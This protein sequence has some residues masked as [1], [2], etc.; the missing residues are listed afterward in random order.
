MSS[1]IMNN[2][3]ELYYINIRN[4]LFFREGTVRVDADGNLLS[5]AVISEGFYC[6]LLNT[7]MGWNLINA[8]SEE[9]NA[10]G[11]DLI[12][13]G[14]KIA[15]Q[16]SLT[17]DH[18]KVQRSIDK[19]KTDSYDGWHF[20]F[21]PI[22]RD[23]PHFREDFSLPAG[24]IFDKSKDVLS[25]DCILRKV[26]ISQENG[27]IDKLKNLS[28]LMD[29]YTK[30]LASHEA[31]CKR[32]YDCLCKARD[33]HP[34]FRLMGEDGIDKQLFPH[35]DELIPALG[36]VDG[37]IAPIWE[38]IKAEQKENF[39]HVI[40][41]G[42]G[43]IG[44][45]VSLLSVTEDNDLLTR[46]PAIYIHMYD[47]VYGGKCLT[48]PEF[49][50]HYADHEEIDQL[51]CE[52]G[53][54]KLMLLLDGLNEVAYEHQDVILRSIKQWASG[55][56]GAQLIIS[57]RPIPGRRL[58]NLLDRDVLHI[59]LKGLEK[60]QI[61][62]RLTAWK[63]THPVDGAAIW[64]TLKL[65][66][67]LTL[68]AK[69]AKLPKQT[70]EGYPLSVREVTGQASLIWNYLQREL[71]REQMGEWP[72][73]CAI[74]CE[75][76]APYIAYRMA[77]KNAFELSHDEAEDLVEDAVGQIDLTVLPTHLK[78]VNA[79]RRHGRKKLP[80]T[81]WVSFVLEQSGIF[82][83]AK[84]GEKD[85]DR[86]KNGGEKVTED[87][88]AFMHQNFRDCLAGLWLVNQAEMAKKGE[89]PG[90]WERNQ[91]H[92]ALNYAAELMEPEDFKRLWK[93]NSVAKK[94]TTEESRKNHTSTCNLLELWKRNKKLTSE[95]DFS[96]MDL[97][98]LSLTHYLG[99]NGE[100]LPL[101][102]KSTLSSG[103]RIDRSVF[104][105]E[106]H[107][108]AIACLAVLPDGRVVSG[109]RDNTL[110]VWDAA[111]GQCLKTLRGH[112]EPITCVAA[113]SNEVII[114]GSED[115]TIGVWNLATGQLLKRLK[116]HTSVVNCVSPLPDGRVI[117]ASDDCTLRV[118]DIDTEESTLLE[119][120]TS[121]ICCIAVLSETNIVS[122]S[123]DGTLR[124]WNTNTGK[125]IPPMN[126][127]GKAITCV[128]IHPNGLIISGSLDNMVRVWDPITRQC[129][130][131]LT[132]LGDGVECLAVLP[133]GMVASATGSIPGAK[134]S[135]IQLW[136][137]SSGEC[138]KTLKGHSKPITSLLVLPDGQVISG[139]D[140]KTIRVWDSA[141]GK[142]LH[143]LKTH[144]DSVSC[145]AALSD[146][147]IISGSFDRSIIIWDPESGKPSQSL[148]NTSL[149]V[150]VIQVLPND[151][152]ITGSSDGVLRLWNYKKGRCLGFLGQHARSVE[153]LSLMPNGML[154]SG[155][156]DSTIQIWDIQSR[157]SKRGIV[158][159]NRQITGLTVLSEA[160]IAFTTGDGFLYRW[161]L[162]AGSCQ[163]EHNAGKR[164]VCV[165][166]LADGK[167]VC[168]SLSK[169][170][171]MIDLH[172][173]TPA[174]DSK[175]T[176]S[177]VFC[178]SALST[179]WVIG[180]SKDGK[181][182][183][184]NLK[185]GEHRPI[186]P[187]Q[188]HQKAVNDITGIEEGR[189]VS[190]SDD[191]TIRVWDLTI[192]KPLESTFICDSPVHCI[193]VL[194]DGKVLSGSL[195]GKIRK[196]DLHSKSCTDLFAFTEVDVYGMDFSKA[197][198]DDEMKKLL[199]Q[200][201]AQTE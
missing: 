78:N 111:T 131:R 104:E 166:S 156:Y 15:L 24:L 72:V 89:L 77:M 63:I 195:D 157:K 27:D 13:R 171:T 177:A 88:Y 3:D 92:I 137:I 98:G 85:N 122:G 125:S 113:L 109:S 158:C 108:G 181:I 35:T 164:L 95:L 165:T 90:L 142:C 14:R 17:C 73:P 58:E 81:D 56:P 12:D 57:S 141:T 152:M 191:K 138:Q 127:G 148:G 49:L 69:T 182:W 84:H 200:S 37:N 54:P 194:P 60:E 163:K 154:V 94:Y 23:A 119:G 189:I 82:V 126:D 106:G 80:E 193:S 123:F 199:Y 140:D 201:G 172:G 136:D 91:N 33:D 62:D 169:T 41:E 130:R 39:R 167:V 51:C 128:A 170:L 43:G 99:K 68:F 120:H 129:L 116:G 8:N 83:A 21:V 71:L 4:T 26:Q 22:K 38:H 187:K 132:V 196:W 53:E 115:Y 97:R 45:S 65:P 74:A 112:T 48:L 9:K 70:V 143:V 107:T 31:L 64:E 16:V 93:S 139:S 135:C 7:L 192:Q 155:S 188:K 175:P 144:A 168:G 105:S 102:Q 50:A 124:V 190:G 11:I 30:D 173:E 117:S 61:R 186:H 52:G 46:I 161:N 185:T 198:I 79:H 110:R 149:A 20:Y 121:L 178:V 42:D 29:K 34:S 174:T 28:H 1:V 2:M 32:L 40:I 6:A 47:L 118:W 179:G 87:E 176:S 76:I 75:Y 66:L 153:A 183:I 197:N 100:A 147:R 180:G 162:D 25:T 19:F 55:H 103:T 134:D 67:F 44:K 151:K 86:G 145:L 133:N 150:N 159:E 36:N 101:F 5:L 146:G 184:W 18:E 59:A 114:S 10:P 160:E 96:G